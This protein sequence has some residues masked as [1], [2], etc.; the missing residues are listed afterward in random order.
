MWRMTRHPDVPEVDAHEAKRRV[1]SGDQFIDVRERDEYQAAHIPGADLVPLSEFV[2]RYREELD[3]E[4]RVVVHCRSGARSA[5]VV[6]FL[7]QQG[8]DA[9]N[10][11][12]GIL[13]WE[14]EG[15][16]VERGTP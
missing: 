6:Q 11:D 9:V 3:K 12:G 1:D 5:R 7:L 13:A 2:D 8:Y 4:R 14:E 10:V 15:L 16:P